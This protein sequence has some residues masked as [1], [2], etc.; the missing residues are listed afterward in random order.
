MNSHRSNYGFW[1]VQVAAVAA[2][3]LSWVAAGTRAASLGTPA[4]GRRGDVVR[5]ER[6]VPLRIESLYNDP[7]LV[8]DEELA[9]VLKQVQPRFTSP[10]LKPNFVEHALRIW[11]IDATFQDQRVYSGAQLKDFLVDHGKYLAAW[12]DKMDPLLIEEPGG[13]SIR[14]G[15]EECGSVHHDHWLA[16]LTE[17]GV[18]LHEAI[19][20]PSKNTRTIDDALQQ[21]LRDFHLDER[22][23]EWSSLGFGLWLPPVK[24]WTTQD[25]RV[26][27]FDMLALRL[28]RG[29]KRFGVCHGTHRLYSMMALI[30]L[31]DTYHILSP[32]VREAGMDRLREVRQLLI[33]SQFPDGHWPSN[34][35]LGADAV[36]KPIDEPL[37]NRVISTGH[38]LEWLAIAPQELHPPRESIRR[39][40]RWAIDTT[41]EKTPAEIEQYYT[42][43]SH[44]GGALALWRQTRPAD[45]W[46]AWEKTHPT[47]EP[48]EATADEAA[49]N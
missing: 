18:P 31:D 22:E 34:W 7:E 27:S 49:S 40:A 35:E 5:I 30:R 1:I 44:V 48:N 21:A 33:D 42:F 8:S 11:G 26:M 10:K 45:F 14:W 47:A 19:F 15:K 37:K 12:G 20:T 43:F 36:K 28:M 4:P 25:G 17:A 6:D 9:G 38:H 16:C 39:A 46:R 41:L 32:E 2:F 13:V 3:G 29:A 23:T 24:Q